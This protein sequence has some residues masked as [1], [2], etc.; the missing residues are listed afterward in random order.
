MTLLVP[1]KARTTHS[2]I[3]HEVTA[4]TISHSARVDGLRVS[5]VSIDKSFLPQRR[6]A[7]KEDAKRTP[8]KLL[9]VFL[10]G[11]APL[12][13]TSN[14]HPRRPRTGLD[15]PTSA[16]CIANRFYLSAVRKL[17]PHAFRHSTRTP[18]S[19]NHAIRPSPIQPRLHPSETDVPLAFPPPFHQQKPA[20]PRAATD[21]H[22]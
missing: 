14:S 2:A 22:R 10:C 8:H 19:C 5:W 7:A 3:R 20:P 11:F 15:L 9:C 17:G 4:D 1:T 6:K 16:T 18:R 12:R 13:E 21:L